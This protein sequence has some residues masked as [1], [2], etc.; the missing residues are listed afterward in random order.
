M[1][2]ESTEDRIER[3]EKNVEQLI[4]SRDRIMEVLQC[5]VNCHV[6]TMGLADGLKN[7]FVAIWG[8]LA[9]VPNL[10]SAEQQRAILDA[11]EKLEAMSLRTEKHQRMMANLFPQLPKMRPMPPPDI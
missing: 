11:V 8:C 1:S 3:L 4:D 6:E 7:Q 10:F 5:S 2:Y 9:I